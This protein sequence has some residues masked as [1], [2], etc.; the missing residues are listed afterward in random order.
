MTDDRPDDDD[1]AVKDVVGV[2]QVLEEAEGRQLE[3]HLQREHAGEDDVADLQDVG[4]LLRLWVFGE[5]RGSY[6]SDG[7][8]DYFCESNLY[9]I[10]KG[11]ACSSDIHLMDCTRF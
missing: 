11:T 10:R 2:P 5:G 8:V 7:K 4:Q 6:V 3:D 1:D 9:F